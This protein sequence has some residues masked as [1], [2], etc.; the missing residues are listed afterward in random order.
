M[1]SLYNDPAV[2]NITFHIGGSFCLTFRL[3]DSA[4]DPLVD[5]T[6]YTIRM[7]VRKAATRPVLADLRTPISLS[8]SDVTVAATAKTYTSAATDFE[9]FGIEVSD[10]VTWTGFANGGNNAALVVTAVS[11]TILTFGDASGL[12]DE[13]A[14]ASVTAAVPRG[15]ALTDPINS[16]FLIEFNKTISENINSGKA[17]DAQYDIFTESATNDVTKLV[18]G[19]FNIK[20]RITVVSAGTE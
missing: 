14:G 19:K 12:V 20:D 13:A 4:G 7:Q 6:N 17:V 16:E 1:A 10:T 5:L 9:D 3:K 15:I 2:H 18:E 8:I 11:T